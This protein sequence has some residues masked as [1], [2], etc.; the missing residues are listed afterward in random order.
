M[1][2]DCPNTKA[3]IVHTEDIFGPDLGFLKGKMITLAVDVIYINEIPFIMTTSQAI[4][5][6]T[7]KM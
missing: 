4:H 3:E 1:I 7:V 6:G 5:F 2:P